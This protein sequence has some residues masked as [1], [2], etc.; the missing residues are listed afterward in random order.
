[1]II[2][3]NENDYQNVNG[4]IRLE[5]IGNNKYNLRLCGD[6]DFENFDKIVIPGS[7][8]DQQIRKDINKWRRAKRNEQ[9]GLLKGIQEQPQ[10]R[11]IVTFSPAEASAYKRMFANSKIHVY[12]H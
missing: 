2:K 10:L 5:P 3:F 9:N 1:M 4:G 7:A 12:W 6:D 11:K 8:L